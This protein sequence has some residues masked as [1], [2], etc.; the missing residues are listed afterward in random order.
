[1]KSHSA[2]PCRPQRRAPAPTRRRAQS[3][4]GT[5]DARSPRVGGTRDWDAVSR[6]RPCTSVLRMDELGAAIDAIADEERFSGVVRVDAG[7]HVRV[8]KAY[9]FA[10]RGY[11]IPNSA[12][13]QFA[14][15]SGT[16]GLT[17]LAVVS[18]IEA[19]SL[20]L[21][22]TARSVLG[23]DLPLIRDDV[24]I[25]HLLAHRS[26]IGDYFDEDSVGDITDYAM[27]VPV[28]ALATT[29]HYLRVLDGHRTN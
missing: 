6:S 9:G 1:G 8:A 5:G 18:L 16:K 21:T 23:E 25:E 28:H 11:E 12:D 10:H 20:A 22:T 4:P 24:T 14:V 2:V 26:G 19:G 27:P 7:D 29:E 13:T 17:A 3:R 15:A